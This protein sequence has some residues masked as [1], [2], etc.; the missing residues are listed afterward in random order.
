MADGSS[1]H[2]D[3]QVTGWRDPE[4]GGLR[5]VSL[6]SLFG[7]IL[8]VLYF[9]IGGGNLPG[10][11]LD[12]VD[13][14]AFR[15]GSLAREVENDFA[16]NSVVA[17]TVR[18][19]YN[20][21]AFRLFDRHTDRVV[22][23]RDHWL[24]EASN[25]KA[26]YP[27]PGAEALIERHLAAISGT[28]SWFAAHGT[29]VLVLPLPNKWALYPDKLPEARKQPRSIWPEMVRGLKARQVW[30]LDAAPALKPDGV[31]TFFANDSHW[32]DQGCL[33]TAGL[34]AEE[35]RQRFGTPLPGLAFD[36]RIVEHEGG[37]WEGDLQRMLGFVKDS[38]FYR[39]FTV[40]RRL[41]R[42]V[43]DRG[44]DLEPEG[45]QT[46]VLCGTSFSHTLHL[47]SKLAALLGR[48]VE[49]RSL[50]G[51]GPTVGLLALAREII[52]G[53]HEA[54]ALIVWEFPE[55][56][57][58]VRKDSFLDP[59]EA[60][61]VERENEE[62]YPASSRR[63]LVITGRTAENV[64]LVDDGEGGLDGT[65]TTGDPMLLVDLGE[66]LPANEGWAVCY[67]VKTA[68]P[69][70]SKILFDWGAGFGRDERCIQPVGGRDR[71]QL[72]CIPVVGPEGRET[73]RFRLD[74]VDSSRPF[75]FRD[76][77]LRRR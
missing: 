53:D 27:R 4:A 54:P 50:P 47:G 57:V 42:V 55:K 21:F 67:R 61:L 12:R 56:H 70:T 1:P 26:N 71:E 38:D 24:F 48:Q 39:S 44:R 59:L 63:E 46:L 34:L 60:F 51:K 13:F 52:A 9:E 2:H 25:A 76:L 14:Q 64:T 16:E 20:E 17:E 33:A 41:V 22:V 58:F 75:E 15:D 45:E 72:I 36:G 10:S 29:K 40:P 31:A 8:V 37:T 18:P 3:Q 23:G 68:N 65:P 74:P 28:V 6:L 32:S 77:H 7:T 5:V 49:D 11:K 73:R 69:T 30:T 19:R 43:D 66:A 62:R 35:I